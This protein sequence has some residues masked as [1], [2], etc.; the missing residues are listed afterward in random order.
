MPTAIQEVA[1]P[2]AATQEQALNHSTKT[3][4]VD[5]QNVAIPS[6]FPS[7]ADWRDCWIYFLMTD[8]FSGLTPPNSQ[9][10]QKFNF[11]QG[12]TF[13]GIR[14]QLG[15]LQQLGV[16]AIWISPV[17]KNSRPN[18]FAFTYP[19]YN[20]QDFLNVDERFSSDGTRA[21]AEKELTA[22]VDEAHAR[23]MYVILD[24]VLN[25]AGRVFDYQLDANTIV[26]SV[27]LNGEK[28]IDWVNGLGF[29]RN[30][31]EDNNL[32]SPANLSPD[33]AIW[34]TDLQHPEFFRRRGSKISDTPDASGFVPGDFGVLRQ[35]VAEYDATVAGQESVRATYGPQPVL[36][37]LV[38]A[39]EYL[40]AKYDVDGFRIDTVK[41]IRPDI[42]ETFGNAMR[43][44]ALSGGKKNFFTFGE[45][46]DREDQ[47]NH[48]IGRNG[49]DTDGFGI[50]AALDFPLFFTL[51]GVAK[52]LQPVE[53][54]RQVFEKRKAAEKDLISSHGEAGKYFVSFLDN[55]DQNQRFNTPSTPQNQITLGLAVL[56]CLQ[57]IPCVYY[58]TE[59]GLQGT[60][61]GAGHPV[62]DSLESVR[63]A[64]WGK[65]P[66][67]FDSGNPLYK[68]LQQIAQLRASEPPL[69]YG[70][71]YFRPVSGNAHDFGQSF[72]N[73]GVIAFSRIL[74]DREVVVV[75]NTSFDQPFR[76]SV[77]VDYDL[78][79]GAPDF[80]IAYSN[81][82][83]S[84]SVS[85]QVAPG[86]VFPLSGPANLPLASLPVSLQGQEVQ[87]LTPR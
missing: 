17:L 72:G 66:V 65:T 31:W 13:E 64:L 58:G 32:P 48:F 28:H 8:R 73:G 47:I 67:P 70:R 30:D 42:V 82:G 15:Y 46:Y 3:V 41:Y 20:T 62:L 35:M 74:T 43:E 56:F 33:D 23:G 80:N 51:P 36:T 49:S 10:D 78:N 11:H 37:I 24:I 1:A 52:A 6:P 57:G 86:N 19:G 45:I 44:Y 71:I 87:I 79:H 84:G 68:D 77:L 4:L 27:P 59:Q 60:N 21:T 34:P 83:S 55:H 50:D 2:I 5:G 81:Q 38:R 9:W 18:Q 22:L 12:G 63:E 75:A 40:I 54:V 85:A 25:H 61:D 69:R 14:R 29:P 76:G 26:D 39:Y 53:S 16:G 7:P